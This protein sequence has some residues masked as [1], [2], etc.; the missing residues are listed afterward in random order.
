MQTQNQLKINSS[1]KKKSHTLLLGSLLVFIG[2]ISIS[3]NYL[4][5]IRDEVYSDMRIAMIDVPPVEEL[6]E[7]TEEEN[8]VVDDVPITE[9][10]SNNK[11]STSYIIDYSKYLGVLEIPKIRLKRGFY[12]TDSK[13]NNIRYNVAMI[14]GSNLPDVDKGNLILI[15]HSGNA[16]YSY[17]AYLYLLGVGDSVSVTYAGKKY[18]YVIVNIYNVPKTGTVRVYRNNTKTTLTMVTCTYG[19]DYSQTVYIAELVN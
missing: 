14:K 11:S 8:E 15:A 7:N 19:D 10:V 5:R 13:Y 9:N 2:I 1:N 17:F 16:Y 3:W 18:D 4:L 6:V 12:G